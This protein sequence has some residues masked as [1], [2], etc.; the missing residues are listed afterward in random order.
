MNVE[1]TG[2][3]TTVTPQLR[4]Q[5][6]AGLEQ[7]GKIVGKAPSGHVILTEDKYRKIAE[8]TV[9]SPAGE[10]VATAENSSMDAALHDALAKLEQQAVRHN[11]KQTAGRRH[12]KDD[13][14]SASQAVVDASPDGL[15]S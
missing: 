2:R 15:L 4:Q 6:E 7:V 9:T 13:L 11:Q 14:K 1:V 5:A 3:Q 8:V 10:F 12:P